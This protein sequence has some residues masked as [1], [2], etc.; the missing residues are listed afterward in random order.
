[1]SLPQAEDHTL[2]TWLQFARVFQKV[3]RRLDRVLDHAG[4]TIPQFDVLANLGM[5]DGITQQELAGR[6]LV[7]KG[8]VCGVLDRME[9]AG[10]VQ[11][12]ADPRDR[13]ANRLHL[14]ERGRA[15]LRDAFP[16]HLGVIQECLAPLSTREQA[17]LRQLLRRVEAGDCDG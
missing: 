9:S 14:T 16:A 2:S 3:Q 11:R 13:R 5:S 6:L 1:M 7:T 15:A 8:N 12:R 17:A 4:L 10:L